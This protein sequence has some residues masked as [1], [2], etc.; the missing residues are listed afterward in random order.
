MEKPTFTV[1]ECIGCGFR[2]VDTSE[3]GYPRDA[4]YIYEE[5]EIGP[6]RPH[7]PH[8][9]RRVRDVLRF[10]QPPGRCLDIGCGKGELAIALAQKGFECAGTDMNPRIISHLQAAAPQVRWS[11]DSAADLKLRSE[12]YDVI[13]LYHVLEHV[14]DPRSVLEAVKSLANPR[15]LIVVEVPNVGGWEARLKGKSWHYYK[16][17]HVGYFR[18][19][20]LV[21]MAGDLDL[22]VADIRGYQHFS[23]PQDVF[24]KDMVKGALGRLGFKDVISIF[25]RTR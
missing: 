21:R 12:R 6:L 2:F 16:V 11:C 23:Y 5:P 10:K 14:D 8:I 13:T 22:E 9:Q 1:R 24:W 7:L 18:K 19:A 25:L 17:D 20:D 3:G 4:Q 15:A